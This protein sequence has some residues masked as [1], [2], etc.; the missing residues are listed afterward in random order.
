MKFSFWQ[1]TGGSESD[2]TSSGKL[3]QTLRPLRP[4]VTNDQHRTLCCWRMQTVCRRNSA[5]PW[6]HHPQCVV[7]LVHHLISSGDTIP[8]CG[9]LSQWH[10]TLI[11]RYQPGPRACGRCQCPWFVLKRFRAHHS[12]LGRLN[13]WGRIVASWTK[14]QLTTEAELQSSCHWEMKRCPL[15][16]CQ[17]I[18]ACMMYSNVD[19]DEE[20][21][22][23]RQDVPGNR[24][25]NSEV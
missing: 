17:T 15:A 25:D 14:S 4:V 21:L 3:F 11:G 23:Q 12:F 19:V 6:I 8:L 2:V 16:P 10:H 1:Y 22:W 13:P 9:T 18:E 7:S 20:G 5:S 24:Q